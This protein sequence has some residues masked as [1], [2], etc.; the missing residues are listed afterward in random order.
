MKKTSSL[1]GRDFVILAFAVLLFSGLAFAIAKSDSVLQLADPNPA[2][3]PNPGHSS[4]EIVV[5]LDGIGIGVCSGDM[6]LQEAVDLGCFGGDGFSVC[7]YRTVFGSY[8]PGSTTYTGDLTCQA[9]GEV[10]IAVCEPPGG[11]NTCTGCKIDTHNSLYEAK[12][13]KRG[14]GE[15]VSGS[16]V[17]DGSVQSIPV[18]PGFSR[19]ECEYSVSIGDIGRGLI[20]GDGYWANFDGQSLKVNPSNWVV[21]YCLIHR[22]S[23]DCINGRGNRFDPVT[24]YYTV[25]CS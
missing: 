17:L 6:A 15:I 9:H 18:P 12:C 21:D 22:N 14:S 10:C 24:V 8:T 16:L 25:S 7:T 3:T 13:C 20:V 1:Q 23:E 19:A 2:N 4:T 11:T 5:N